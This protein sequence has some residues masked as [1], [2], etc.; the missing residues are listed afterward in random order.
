[1]KRRNFLKYSLAGSALL[2]AF[3]YHLLA[4]DKKLYPYDRVQLGKTGIQVSRMAMG[5]GT[6]GGNGSSNQSRQLGIK[7][8]A[9]LLKAAFDDGINFWDSANQYGTH[10]HLKEALKSIDRD[11][12]VIL[13]KTNSRNYKDVK[14]DLDRFRREIG[15]DRLDMVLLHCVTD[16][17]WNINLKGAMEALSEAKEAGI[18]KAHG[19]SCHSIGA[20]ESAADEPWVD[21]DLAR[22]NPGGIAMDADVAT[23]TKVLTRMKQNGKVIIG[24][25]VYG[26]G[27]LVHKKDECLEFHT[28]SKFIDAFTLG[29]ESIEQ[30]RDVQKRLPEASVRG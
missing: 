5:T 15:T 17:K 1:M 14:A 25:K 23:V 19:V 24:M 16:S 3:P 6:N 27:E 2:S 28:G 4:G 18:I 11:K 9:D 8:V 22:Y 21:I 20:L 30:L 13:T 26:A 29:I 7:G 10:A 12:V